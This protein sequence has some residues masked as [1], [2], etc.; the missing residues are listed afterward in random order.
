MEVIC[1]NGKISISYRNRSKEKQGVEFLF[2]KSQCRDCPLREKCT[3]SKTIRNVFIGE[4]YFDLKKGR[5]HYQTESYKEASKNRYRIERRHAD[6]VRNHGLR[7]SRYR[8]LERT[9]IHS[10]LSSMASNIKRMSKLIL[11]R[12]PRDQSALLPT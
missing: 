8:G 9:S 7:R 2:T 3:H 11:E 10:L 12:K 5:E 6:K 4:Y 1:P